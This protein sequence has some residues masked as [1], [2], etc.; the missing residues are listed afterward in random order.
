[1]SFPPS[2]SSRLSSS[3]SASMRKDYFDRASGAPGPIAIPAI[4]GNPLTLSPITPQGLGGSYSSGLPTLKRPRSERPDDLEFSESEDSRVVSS[5]VP[6]A[7]QKQATDEGGQSE[8]KEEDKAS[9]GRALK[10]SKR[11]A[12]NRAAQQAFRRRKEDRIKELEEKER[13]LTAYET[14]E[15]ELLHREE[16]LF[17]REAA[18]RNIGGFNTP[19]LP[20]LDRYHSFP[21]TAESLRAPQSS[22]ESRSTSESLSRTEDQHAITKL[23]NDLAVAQAEIA[24]LSLRLATKDEL[25]DGLR[26]SLGGW[27]LSHFCMTL[28]L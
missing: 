1:M 18:F 9:T 17:K 6:A 21:Q 20:Q 8:E 26:R 24:S 11:A 2:L 13:Q 4:P 23:K 10:Q 5:G 28:M 15:R 27:R 22:H 3:G 7:L 14:R 16:T 25:C 19:P 12:Q